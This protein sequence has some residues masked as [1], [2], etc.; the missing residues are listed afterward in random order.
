MK[1]RR[2]KYT[3]LMIPAAAFMI[4]TAA[5]FPGM[6][7]TAA[8]ISAE[9]GPDAQR[10]DDAEDG[11]DAQAADAAEGGIPDAQE[12]DT[13]AEGDPDAQEASRAEDYLAGGGCGLTECRD[14]VLL[15]EGYTVGYR[16]CGEMYLGLYADRLE[17]DGSW[18]TVWYKELYEEDSYALSFCTKICVEKGHY[19]RLRA[20]HYGRE[21]SA[22]DSCFSGTDGILVE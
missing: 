13:A 14:G 5:V 7:G 2:I 4:M 17:E 11:P 12:E 22:Y 16:M 3:V 1:N 15:L 9:G 19:Y 18:A 10:T 8:E 20:G 21:G 6:P